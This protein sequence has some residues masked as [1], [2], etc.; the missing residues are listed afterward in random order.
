M[1][2]DRRVDAVRQGLE[3]LHAALVDGP[4]YAPVP[5]CPE[6]TMADLSQHVGEF[7]GWWTQILCDGSGRPDP[8][9]F[10]V[11]DPDDR[12][13]WF[14]EVGA[15]L[16][17]ELEATPASTEVW[18]WAKDDK[19]AGFVAR[20]CAHELAIHRYDAQM[21]R[22]TQQPIDAVVASDGIDEIFVMLDNRGPRSVGRG[23]T[24]HLHATDCDAEW[25]LTLTE[26]GI[27]VLHEH[28]KGDAAI[29]GAVSDIELL[30]YQR[31]TIGEV[32]SFGDT[33]P[34]E[35]FHR[36]FTF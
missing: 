26:D 31:P 28:G 5:T 19:T 14:A 18:T 23:E 16:L 29:R 21:A 20:R 34:L 3:A 30:L 36:A 33:R 35:L 27:S 1:D 8:P 9:P 24:L 7:A 4:I 12:P 6:W 15:R 2:H 13:A 11:P 17:T 32:E 10:A 22:G 25:M